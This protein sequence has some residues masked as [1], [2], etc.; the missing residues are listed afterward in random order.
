MSTKWDAQA[1]NWWRQLTPDERVDIFTNVL[2]PEMERM[3]HT[4]QFRMLLQAHIAKAFFTGRTWTLWESLCHAF[5]VSP[6]EVFACLA[7]N[8]YPTLVKEGEP[9]IWDPSQ[10][11]NKKE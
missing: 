7:G 11:R 2:A 9:L 6:N 4:D 3:Q 8:M 5:A 10:E 1:R